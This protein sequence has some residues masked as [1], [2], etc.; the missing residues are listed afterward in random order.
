MGRTTFSASTALALA[1]VLVSSST[2]IFAVASLPKHSVG[3]KQLKTSAVTN[4]K[5]AK[6]AI[7]SSKV[8]PNALGG[9]AINE[10][11]LGQVPSSANAARLAQRIAFGKGNATSVPATTV[12]SLPTVG[13]T[14]TTDGT[15]STDPVVVV[16]L[17]STAPSFSW[18]IN[19]SFESQTFSTMGDR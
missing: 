5:I 16:N 9:T 11:A 7:T 19:S 4:K 13:L 1:A 18:I 8:K 17:P 6:H 15:A 10:S 3:A 12:L 14:V 2:A